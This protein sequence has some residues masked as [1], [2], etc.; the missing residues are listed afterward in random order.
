MSD[1]TRGFQKIY[2]N[3]GK[4]IIQDGWWDPISIMSILNNC[5]GDIEPNFWNGKKVIDIGSNT[6]GLSVEIAR[7][8]AKVTAVEPDQRAIG[9]F[10][11]ALPSL[12]QENLQIELKENTLKDVLS[13]EKSYDVILFLGLLYHFKYPQ[14]I[15]NALSTIPHRWLFISTQCTSKSGL[16]QVNR[17]EEMPERMRVNMSEMTGWHL[18]R[19]LLF[20]M[21]HDAGWTNIREGSDPKLH[22]SN[23]PQSITN[24]TYLIAER[25]APIRAQSDA[26]EELYKF[27]PR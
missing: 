8:G 20:Q 18:S 13:W 14:F 22:F 3:D 10:R 17:L 16:V 24:S 15:I 7:K 27:Y 23:K 4:T 26:L 9:R 5:I 12:S 1:I 11:E 19:P 6:C 2:A 25:T 21:L